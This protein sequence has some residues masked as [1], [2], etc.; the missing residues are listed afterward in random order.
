MVGKEFVFYTLFCIVMQLLSL[1]SL[2]ATFSDK[3]NDGNLDGWA[4]FKVDAGGLMQ[5]Y[6][7]E[8]T[9]PE[10]PAADIRAFNNSELWMAL[11]TNVGRVSSWDL[12]DLT[13]T[14][15]IRLMA[16]GGVT[17]RFYLFVRALKQKNDTVGGGPSMA[18]YIREDSVRVYDSADQQVAEIGGGKMLQREWH[19]IKAVAEGIHFQFYFDKMLV[20]ELDDKAAPEMGTIAFYVSCGRF[21]IDDFVLTGAFSVQPGGR[22]SVAWGNLKYQR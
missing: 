21:Q 2:A 18:I 13:L 7:D 20:G 22:L 3:F 11:D 14:A 12:A 15:R 5:A 16:Q 10:N 6:V 9:D 19:N 4:I 1:P 17:P 8:K